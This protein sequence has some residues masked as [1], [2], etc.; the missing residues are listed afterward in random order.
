MPSSRL[1]NSKLISKGLPWKVPAEVWP[2]VRF[3]GF[4]ETEIHSEF[5]MR[6]KARILSGSNRIS[7]PLP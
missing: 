7:V 5:N 6:S 1:L 3:H 2:V 4:E